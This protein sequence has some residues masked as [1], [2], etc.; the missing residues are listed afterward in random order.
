[1]F[2]LVECGLLLQE[3]KTSDI[4]PYEKELHIE[5]HLR[6]YK[7]SHAIENCYENSLLNV[8]YAHQCELKLLHIVHSV[9]EEI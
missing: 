9:D 2:L 1:M 4:E 8:Q 3:E 5:Y 7:K 6:N